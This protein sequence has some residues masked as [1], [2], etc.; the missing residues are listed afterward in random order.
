MTPK[1]FPSKYEVRKYLEVRI[2]SMNPPPSLE[3]IRRQV[4]WE[5]L[6]TDPLDRKSI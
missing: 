4:G 3:E 1:I 6:K 5:L 2:H